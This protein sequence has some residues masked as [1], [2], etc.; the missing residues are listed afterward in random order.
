MQTI[1]D[2]F[3]NFGL[4]VQEKIIY[5]AEICQMKENPKQLEIS[6]ATKM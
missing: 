6:V 3:A 1:F 5:Q 4:T 2:W